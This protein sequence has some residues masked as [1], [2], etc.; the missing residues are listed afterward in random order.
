MS[1]PAIDVVIE[2]ANS[3]PASTHSECATES[4][5]ELISVPRLRFN[6]LFTKNGSDGQ[7]EKDVATDR[8]DGGLFFFAAREE[9]SKSRCYRVRFL[10]VVWKTKIK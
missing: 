2:I 3:F 1:T 8:I 10:S 6:I 7:C 4:A 9:N 5:E